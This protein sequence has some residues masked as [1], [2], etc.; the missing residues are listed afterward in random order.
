[1]Y[2][3]R[4]REVIKMKFTVINNDKMFD[5]YVSSLGYAMVDVSIYE[6]VRPNRKIFFRTKF[7]PFH[8]GSFFATDFDTIMEGALSVLEKGYKEKNRE[9]KLIEKWKNFEKSIDKP[10]IL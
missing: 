1:M 2:T 10:I 7:F 5:I 9:E 6:V 3:E 8:T 4:K